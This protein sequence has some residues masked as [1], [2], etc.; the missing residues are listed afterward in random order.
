MPAQLVV[1][2]FPPE[3]TLEEVAQGLQDIGAP[4]LHIEA[5]NEGDPERRSF[6]LELD[7]EPHTLR[8]MVDRRHDRFYRDRKI[9][10]FMP[11]L[12]N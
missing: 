5:V 2:N 9:T 7:I 12:M 4:V 6:V 3:A 10:V 8:I 1:G 11:S